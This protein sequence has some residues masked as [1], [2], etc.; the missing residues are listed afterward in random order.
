MVEGIIIYSRWRVQFYDI[1]NFR[2]LH[3]ISSNQ[4]LMYIVVHLTCPSSACVPPEAKKHPSLYILWHT[5]YRK[6]IPSAKKTQHVQTWIHFRLPTPQNFNYC[7]F[8]TYVYFL[9]TS[10]LNGLVTQ[11]LIKSGSLLLRQSTGC[12]QFCN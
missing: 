8:Q 1:Y 9:W 7:A 5:S 2:M 10:N 6:K 4:M 12:V 3:L 11:V